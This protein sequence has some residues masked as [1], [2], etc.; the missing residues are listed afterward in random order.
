ME[1]FEIDLLDIDIK[2]KVVKTHIERELKHK[3]SSIV[4]ISNIYY[5]YK[6]NLIRI[7]YKS[8][9]HMNDWLITLDKFLP[10]I[11]LCQGFSKIC[12]WMRFCFLKD[13]YDFINSLS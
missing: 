1:V 4:D 5:L 9:M 10:K 3:K 2:D 11:Y 12:N 8:K 13:F 7:F 6:L